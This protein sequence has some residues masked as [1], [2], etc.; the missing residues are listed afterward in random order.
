[1]TVGTVSYSITAG[2]DDGVFAIDGSTG[3]ITVAAALE[4]ETTASY[5]LM[6]EAGNGKTDGVATSTSVTLFG[7]R[8]TPS[9][10]PGIRC[11]GAGLTASISSDWCTGRQGKHG[12]DLHGHGRD[13]GHP[14]RLPGQGHQCEGDGP[15][16]NSETAITPQ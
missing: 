4:Y 6:V 12:D 13:A 16:S 1:M 2:N 9:P 10:S 11:C 8:P 3:A 14:L 5:T 15:Y 7:R